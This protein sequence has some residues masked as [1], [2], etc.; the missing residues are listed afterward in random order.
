MRA[1]APSSLLALVSLL[2]LGGC[3]LGPN[4]ERPAIDTPA[5]F[6]F[7][8]DDAKEIVDTVW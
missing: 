1:P 7:A 5:T 6:R 3:L 2:A 8:M 4:Y